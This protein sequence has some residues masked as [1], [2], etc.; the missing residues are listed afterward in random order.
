LPL[1]AVGVGNSATTLCH[2]HPTA[3]NKLNQTCNLSPWLI[4][5]LCPKFFRI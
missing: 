4:S 1:I 3:D 5:V 2:S